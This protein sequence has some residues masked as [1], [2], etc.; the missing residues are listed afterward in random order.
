MSTTV[1][2]NDQ[3]IYPA[4]FVSRTLEPID[5][6]GRWGVTQNI[7]LNG[8]L[9]GTAGTGLIAGL[10]D[11]FATGFKTLRIESDGDADYYVA[12]NCVLDSISISSNPF[13]TGSNQ[14][15]PY[16]VSMKSYAVPSGVIDISNEYSYADNQDGT[17]SV[18]RK[19]G[20]KG[21]KTSS[22]D[23]IDNAINFVSA[24][25]GVSPIGAVSPV[26]IPSGVPVLLSFSES[27]N[28]LEG[29]YAVNESWKYETGSTVPYVT[30]STL[31]ISDDISSEYTV[32]DLEVNFTSH[33]QSGITHVRDYA[34]DYD[35]YGK[36]ESYGIGTGNCI[37][38]NFSVDQNPSASTI[39]AKF[40]FISG[41]MAEIQTGIFYHSVTM[42]W[43]QIRDVRTFS[44]N[45]DFKV[46]GPE[47]HRANLIAAQKTRM[48]NDYGH[49]VA[50]LYCAIKN[51]E[52]YSQLASSTYPLSPLPLD[53]NIEEGTRPPSL[54]MS[55]KFDDASWKA[56]GQQTLPNGS[57]Y[58]TSIGKASWRAS[59]TPELWMFESI[60]AANIEGHFVIQDMQCKTRERIQLNSAVEHVGPSYSDGTYTN[61]YRSYTGIT[62]VA[63]WVLNQIS[64]LTADN[65]FYLT[66]STESSGVFNFDIGR[67]YIAKTGVC[68]E[69][70]AD[71]VVMFVN[72]GYVKR[73]PGYQF[74]Y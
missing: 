74:G 28:R 14:G 65:S 22:S 66:D 58:P 40:S 6:G 2:Y 21:L 33:K 42:D 54:K 59:V 1:K 64:G 36:L 41:E 23:A 5:I 30:V 25:T 15:I 61:A 7:E 26:F 45:S 20:A 4:P 17:V 73:L 67:S 44:I 55:A 53:F 27:I 18:S 69:I 71:K 56:V 35:Y 10:Y 57:G 48:I 50:Y 12:E 19:M 51:T 63:S 3:G 68:R 8:F 32:L 60:P 52:L 29:T 38:T 39:G 72:N 9:T 34:R 24:L 46:K 13:Y 70:T 62:G 49:Y 11:I 16:T 47:S 43:D 31:N 37:I